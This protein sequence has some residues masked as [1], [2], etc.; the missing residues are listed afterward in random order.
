MHF[1]NTSNWTIPG[2]RVQDFYGLFM[3]E[4]LYFIQSNKKYAILI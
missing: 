2:V 1:V 3:I 4:Y